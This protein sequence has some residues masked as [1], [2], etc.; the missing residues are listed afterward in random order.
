MTE[1]FVLLELIG[2]E[3]VNNN[4]TTNLISK[5]QNISE[6][7]IEIEQAEGTRNGKITSLKGVSR[8]GIF[9][10]MRVSKIDAA[11]K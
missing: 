8:I 4:N 9:E 5:L 6:G 7:D 10:Q 3:T 2:R 11:K 1:I